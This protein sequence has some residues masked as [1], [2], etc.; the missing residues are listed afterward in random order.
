MTQDEIDFITLFYSLTPEM[1]KKKLSAL[2][3]YC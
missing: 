3:K 1:Q 2:L